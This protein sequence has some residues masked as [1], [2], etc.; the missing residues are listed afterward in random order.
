MSTRTIACI[1][2]IAFVAVCFLAAGCISTTVGDVGYR[3]GT[4]SVTITSPSGPAD[5]YV[6]VTVY[7]VKDLHQ[8]EVAVFEKPVNL[9]QGEN[10]VSIPGQIGPGQYKLYV[11][12]LQN[13]E[14]KTA[15]IRDITV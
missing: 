6:Q 8:E 2:I 10:T 14:R 5:A 12:V 7:Q 11:Y 1:P 3:N 4:V 9:V 15:V 13:G